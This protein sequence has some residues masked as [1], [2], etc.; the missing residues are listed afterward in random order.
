MNILYFMNH[1]PDSRNGGIENVTRVLSEQ[2]FKFGHNVHIRYL[3]NSKFAHSNDSIFKSCKQIDKKDII[4]EIGIAVMTHKID[5]VI[6]QGMISMSPHLKDAIK[7]AKCALITAFHGQPSISP[8]PFKDIIANSKIPFI[9]KTL[10]LLTY[11]FFVYQSKRKQ[12]ARCQNSYEIC[13]RTV[14]LS[15]LH[16]PEYSKM[17]D[18]NTEKLAYMNNPLKDTLILG[19]QDLENKENSILIVSRLSEREKCIIK[20]LIIWK[21]VV[22]TNPTWNLKVVGSGPDENIIKEYAQKHSIKNVKFYPAQEPFQFYRKASILLMTSRSEG[23]GCTIT[24]A[25]RLGCV[26]VAMGTYTAINDIIT[27]KENGIIIRPT[28]QSNDIKNCAKAITMLINDKELLRKMAE[29]ANK[30]TESLSAEVIAKQ[31]I[32]LFEECIKA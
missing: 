2:F 13:D 24:E 31:W 21:E 11:P 32:K 25:M 4:E 12:K 15:R 22:K 26:P 29:N 23:W 7:E 20:S 9:K 8:Q 5:V 19:S 10:I 16:I 30:R 14:L 17:L 28:T 3:L 1:Y 27:D 18:I 6:N